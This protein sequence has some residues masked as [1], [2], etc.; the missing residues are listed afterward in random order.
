M[1]CIKQYSILSVVLGTYTNGTYESEFTFTTERAD[2]YSNRKPFYKGQRDEFRTFKNSS[3]TVRSRADS[4][5]NYLNSQPFRSVLAWN[6]GP[7]LEFIFPANIQVT[8]YYYPG[9]NYYSQCPCDVYALNANSAASA[10]ATSF[11]TNIPV[12]PPQ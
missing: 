6:S 11:P 2:F 4:A 7:Q 3:C 9:T 8:V 5:G 10:G 1:S 12:P